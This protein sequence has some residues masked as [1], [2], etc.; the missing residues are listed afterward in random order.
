MTPIEPVMVCGRQR[1][2]PLHMESQYFPAGSGDIPLFDNDRF[3]PPALRA[4]PQRQCRRPAGSPPGESTR[5]TMGFHPP[6]LPGL[7]YL[8]GG[9]GRHP[10]S[11]FFTGA[12]GVD[13]SKFCGGS[14][15]IIIE[16]FVPHGYCGRGNQGR[17][18]PSL[19]RCALRSWS[20]RPTASTRLYSRL[21]CLG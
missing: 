9:G 15:L 19:P 11:N 2:Y 5:K 8:I 16:R 21:P 12:K 20:Q 6:V 14:P 1:W 4:K 17:F 3:F 10:P 18:F 13:N 7:R